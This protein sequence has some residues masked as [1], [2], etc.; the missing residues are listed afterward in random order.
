MMR[1]VFLLI[2]LFVGNEDNLSIGLFIQKYR[3]IV[4]CK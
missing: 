3:V 1:F 2:G 4:Y